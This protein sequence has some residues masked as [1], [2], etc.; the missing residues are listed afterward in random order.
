MYSQLI[1]FEERDTDS[2]RARDKDWRTRESRWTDR[3]GQKERQRQTEVRV[4]VLG[5]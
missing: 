2:E 1:L 3:V 5:G 4:C